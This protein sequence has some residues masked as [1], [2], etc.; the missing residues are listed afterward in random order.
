M[1]KIPTLFVREE[2]DGKLQRLV[3][4]KVTPGCEWVFEG[5]GLPT[6]KRDGTAIEIKAGRVMKRYTL[7]PGREIPEGFEPTGEPDPITGTL[8]G[9]AP[10]DFAEPED[11]WIREAVERAALAIEQAE[12]LGAPGVPGA[13]EDGTYEVCGPKIG[14][15]HGA[16]ANPEGLGEHRLFKHGSEILK[17]VV[18]SYDGFKN[19]FKVFRIEG[20]V[21]HHPDG[22]TMAKIKSA[23]LGIPWGA[24]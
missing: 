24:A 19:F 13:L 2:K 5:K 6:R 12:G 7:K 9:W 18:R 11:K 1:H 8:S 16:G 3:T 17:D 21:F 10:T 22:V 4:K 23:D 14:G 15:G 20:I